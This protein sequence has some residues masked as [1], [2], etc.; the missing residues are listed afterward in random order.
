MKVLIIFMIFFF[1]VGCTGSRREVKDLNRSIDKI[2][3][4]DKDCKDKDR[5]QNK[6]NRR[7]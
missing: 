7:N 1:L 5:R 3:I 4:D 6:R 2:V